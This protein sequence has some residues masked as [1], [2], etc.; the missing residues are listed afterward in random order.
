LLRLPLA[1]F[2]AR[3]EVRYPLKDEGVETLNAR[4]SAKPQDSSRCF[5]TFVLR[6][7]WPPAGFPLCTGPWTMP[8]CSTRPF[9]ALHWSCL[10]TGGHESG[11]HDFEQTAKRENV[12]AGSG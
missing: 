2:N 12:S 11:S 3:T 8:A 10:S 4:V 7:A 6:I 1:D 5:T 9:T